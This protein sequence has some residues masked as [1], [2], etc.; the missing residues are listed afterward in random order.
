MLL[1]TVCSGNADV[2][3]LGD[4]VQRNN[5]SATTLASMDAFVTRRF[6]RLC[7]LATG[8][9][10]TEWRLREAICDILLACIDAFVTRTCEQVSHSESLNQ[11]MSCQ[12]SPSFGSE[13]Y[14]RCR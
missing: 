14:E 1:E 11:L 10:W 4:R 2:L 6:G 7:V 3:I 5:T 12:K 13:S 9:F 8:M